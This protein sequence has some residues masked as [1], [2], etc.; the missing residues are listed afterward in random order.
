MSD[1]QEEYKCPPVGL[2]VLGIEL[3]LLKYFKRTVV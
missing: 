3:C 1:K 2:T